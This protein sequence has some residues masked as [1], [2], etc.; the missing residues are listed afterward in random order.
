MK[1]SALKIWNEY[2]R[3]KITFIQDFA[4][5]DG[6]MFNKQNCNTKTETIIIHC[7]IMHF[8]IDM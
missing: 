8:I 5:T 2:I 7:I 3:M 1:V 6:V 4:A